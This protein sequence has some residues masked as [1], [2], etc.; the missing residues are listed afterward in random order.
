MEPAAE[1]LN[2]K[3]QA[4]AVET[5]K[6]TLIHNVDVA[7]HSAAE[8][9]RNALK[10]QLFKPVRWADG[11][12]YMHDQGV[13]KFVECGPGKVLMGVNKRIVKS[14]DHMTMYD[15]PT[16]NKVLEQLNG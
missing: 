8:V 13:T 15:Q 16:L 4:I 1:K 6:M 2:E 10:E 12:R 3:L 11:V 5:P 9:I 7:A 14:A